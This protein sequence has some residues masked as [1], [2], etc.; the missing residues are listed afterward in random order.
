[1]LNGA[2]NLREDDFVFHV[3]KDPSDPPDALLIVGFIGKSSKP[4]CVRIY[5]DVML[6][7][8]IDLPERSVLHGQRVPESQSPLGGWYIWVKRDLDLVDTVRDA[9]AKMAEIQEE[10]KHG[11]QPEADSFGEIGPGW[12]QMPT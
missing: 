5:L 4:E 7:A 2:S 1:M 3:V 6:G 11:I 10:Y 9:Y 8:Y 12:P